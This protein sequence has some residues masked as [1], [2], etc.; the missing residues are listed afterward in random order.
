MNG[1][2]SQVTALG[3]RHALLVYS[4]PS[5]LFRRI[6]DTGAYGWRNICLYVPG[7]LTGVELL[8]EFF[9][10]VFDSTST[11]G[12]E[13]YEICQTFVVDTVRIVN[14]TT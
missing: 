3:V 9:C 1:S 8:P 5:A 14:K 11:I 6:E 10:I 13:I 7:S 12:F 2:E 4:S